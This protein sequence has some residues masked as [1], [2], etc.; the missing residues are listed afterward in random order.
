MVPKAKET[1]GKLVLRFH[2]YTDKASELL[3]LSN[4]FK[5]SRELQIK[6]RK[7]RINVIREKNTIPFQ[8]SPIC[9]L[10]TDSS[11]IASR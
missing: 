8:Y 7:N 11:F 3:D 5:S 10:V 2:G 1:N 6:Q 4:C 9:M